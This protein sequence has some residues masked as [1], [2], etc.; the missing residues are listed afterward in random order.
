MVYIDN[1][2]LVLPVLCWNTVM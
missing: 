2:I 1:I